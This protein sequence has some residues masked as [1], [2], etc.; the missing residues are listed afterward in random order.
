MALFATVPKKAKAHD[1]NRVRV[2][3]KSEHVV[4]DTQTCWLS[5]VFLSKS[6]ANDNM[7]ARQ[8]RWTRVE[9]A[10]CLLRDGGE[11]RCNSSR[12]NGSDVS[13][14]LEIQHPRYTAVL[15]S[16]TWRYDSLYIQKSI[17]VKRYQIRCWS[18]SIPFCNCPPLSLSLSLSLCGFLCSPSCIPMVL[19]I[20]IPFVVL[21]V[22]TRQTS[23]VESRRSV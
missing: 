9:D 13:C 8:T 5:L 3:K 4:R 22:Y 16:R 11:I 23:T 20:K 7:T 21:T 18:R 15:Y 6:L 17:S 19:G 14:A 12:V 1:I 10:D 2:E